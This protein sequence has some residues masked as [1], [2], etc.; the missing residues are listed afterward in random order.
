MTTTMGWWEKFELKCRRADLLQEYA[1]TFAP[2]D[3]P[4]K[5][6][7]RKIIF[8]QLCAIENKLPEEERLK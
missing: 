6:K 5:R 2:I 8:N 4:G 1:S 7:Q 3:S